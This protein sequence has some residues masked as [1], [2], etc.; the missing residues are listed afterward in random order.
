MHDLHLFLSDQ[1][2]PF[3]S[4][5]PIV[6]YLHEDEPFLD[7]I[8]LIWINLGLA[9]H[10]YRKSTS[11]G[12]KGST[13]NLIDNSLNEDSTMNLLDDVFPKCGRHFNER[14][15]GCNGA[16]QYATL[17][18]MEKQ[19]AHRSLK[20]S[21]VEQ[22]L[23]VGDGMDG[24]DSHA[25]ET[26]D[27]E[28]NQTESQRIFT[29]GRERGKW[30]VN[31]IDIN[32]NVTEERLTV[33]D[34]WG[35]EKRR[36]ILE[37][38]PHNQPERGSGGIFGTWLGMLSTDLNKFPINYDDWRNVLQWRKDDAWDYIKTKFCFDSSNKSYKDFV[39]KS[40]SVKCKGLKTRLWDHL[41]R[42]TPEETLQLRPDFIPK[43]Q[44]QDFV[45]MQFSEKTKRAKQDKKKPLQDTTHFRKK[46]ISRVS[47][48]IFLKTGKRPSRA[49][50]FVN[51]RQKANGSFVSKEA[52]DL[53]EK[54]T[55]KMAHTQGKI[56]TSD[57]FSQVFGSERP[58]RVRCVGLGPTPS[59]FFKNRTSYEAEI[60]E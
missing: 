5:P 35:M 6:S 48:E 52:Q 11:M 32:G 3:V 12:L 60:I 8:W 31:V 16:S 39:M 19:Q 54:L 45:Y 22:I 59:T 42:N 49:E 28:V 40:L 33:K 44:W 30:V 24:I 27:V 25:E 43:E 55:E 36:I 41:G 51:S 57:E 56:N 17:S 50:I 37:F 53:S 34:V 58:G 20:M 18:P 23:V 26:Q 46:S 7:W 14:A 47:K 21:Y 2:S 38:G 15:G 4:L 13:M 1:G 9:N 10:V 29:Q